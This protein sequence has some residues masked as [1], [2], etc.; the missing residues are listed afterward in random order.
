LKYLEKENSQHWPLGIQMLA[1]RI[2][3]AVE[4][5]KEA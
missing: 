3:A 1:E 4:A 2:A 5:E